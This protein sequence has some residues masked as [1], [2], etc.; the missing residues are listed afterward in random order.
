MDYFFLIWPKNRPAGNSQVGFVE[1]E[2]EREM[3]GVTTLGTWGGGG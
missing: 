1:E 2:E 3:T